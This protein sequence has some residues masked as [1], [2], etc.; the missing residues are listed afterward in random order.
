MRTVMVLHGWIDEWRE[1]QLLAR[2]GAEPGDIHRAVD[3]ADWL[4]HS[5]GELCKLFGKNET[6][7][8]VELLRRRVASGV[9]ED[10]V[11]LTILQGV[12]R[13]RARGLYAAGY[14]S[15]EDIKEATAERLALVEKIGPSLARK[16]KEQVSRH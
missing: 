15:L 7:R 10:I 3:N 1:E 13:V 11:E 8:Q 9:S 4:L 2:F 14:R 6:G 12:G 16:I 5:L